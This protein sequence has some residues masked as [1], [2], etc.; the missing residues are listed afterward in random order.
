MAYGLI[1][2]RTSA[3]DSGGGSVTRRTLL[4]GTALGLVTAHTSHAAAQGTGRVVRPPVRPRSA[5]AGDLAPVGELAPEQVRFFVVHHSASA[6]GYAAAKVPAILRSFYHHHTTAKGWPDVAYNF[7]IDRFGTIWEG[8]RGSL[9]APVAGSATG[10]NQGFAQL[11]CFVGNFAAVRPTSAALQSAEILFAWLSSR[12]GVR[13]TTEKSVSFV[14]RG[15]NKLPAGQ[16]VRTYPITGH[17]DLSQTACPGDA[18]YA[19]L[20]SVIVPGV[21]RRTGAAPSTPTSPAASA[22]PVGTQPGSSSVSATATTNQLPATPTASPVTLTASATGT[23]PAA[24]VQMTSPAVPSSSSSV[25]A[26]APGVVDVPVESGNNSSTWVLASLGAI[27]AAGATTAGVLVA[28]TKSGQGAG[29]K[30]R[31]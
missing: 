13:V 28:K 19:A 8:R 17:R 4:T 27:A 5:W 24:S 18:L 16:R 3:P 7:F 12:Y 15:S 10:G 14:S 9:S 31:C 30:P 6:N 1:M 11:V 25:N 21:I 22:T 26:A 29:S 20:P 23:T 2:H